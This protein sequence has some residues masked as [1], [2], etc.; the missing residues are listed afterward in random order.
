VAASIQVVRA[1]IRLRSI[2]AAHK[3]L[4]H[5][6]AGMEKKYDCQFKIVFDG[7]SPQANG[8]G[9]AHRRHDRQAAVSP[10]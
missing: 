5:K 1:F 3:E 4:A 9:S 7:N 8:H 2:L 10:T 6:I